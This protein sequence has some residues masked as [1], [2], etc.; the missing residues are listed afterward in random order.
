MTEE[1]RGTVEIEELI[2]GLEL[3][4]INVAKIAK[5]GVGIDDIKYVVE[6]IKEYKVLVDAVEGL[7]EALLE[8]KDIDQSELMALGIRIFG[9][10]KN[11]KA[12]LK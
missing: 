2:D 3:V 12:A 5:D 9:V 8:A 11:I 7:D 6:L 10:F 1:S 4:G